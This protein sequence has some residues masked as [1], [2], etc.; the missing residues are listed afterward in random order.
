ML[1][2]PRPLNLTSKERGK[3]KT[4]IILSWL[5]EFRVSS[6]QILSARIGL[7]PTSTT[8]FFKL[9]L[10]RNIIERIK[11]FNSDRRDLVILGT[12]GHKILG[13]SSL[14]SAAEI[15]RVR[16]YTKKKTIAHDL[17]AQKAVL[18]LLWQTMEVVSDFNVKINKKTPDALLY[19]W[20]SD[21]KQ[22]RACAVE[23]EKTAKGS[24]AIY[25]FFNTYLEILDSGEITD[26]YVFFSHEDDLKTYR[27]YFDRELWP[28]TGHKRLKRNIVP[29][30]VMKT[31]A[32]DDWRRA[33][34]KFAILAP[35]EE[36]AIFSLD[37]AS[38][39]ERI[40][41][42]PYLERWRD[43]ERE[44]LINKA[45]E[46][47]K[48]KQEEKEEEERQ[49]LQE[50]INERNEVSE[51]IENRRAK[52][53]ALGAAIEKAKAEDESP[54]TWLPGYKSQTRSALEA[55]VAYLTEQLY[56]EDRL[57]LEAYETQ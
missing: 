28:T 42:V 17:E 15:N 35:Q 27:R 56:L 29:T 47:K 19:R 6:L 2:T 34:F 31:V 20:N 11:V 14:E 1:I 41:Q 46:E 55:L 30:T 9:L 10:E 23:M 12:E 4:K 21:A 45:L 36:P 5:L 32:K 48:K 53:A 26:V 7:P 57:T 51:R 22:V 16:K 18:K 54:K 44:P 43:Q 49:A 37:K 33:R 50:E 39:L 52:I 3:E 25:F 24:K 40:L 8:R 38:K 13:T